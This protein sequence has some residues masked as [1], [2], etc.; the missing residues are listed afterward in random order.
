MTDKE[1]QGI[2]RVPPNRPMAE[3]DSLFEF[4]PFQQELMDELY[5]RET[6]MGIMYHGALR[7][8]NDGENPDRFSLA[9]HSIREMLSRL[10]DHIGVESKD[11]RVRL[12]DRVSSLEQSWSHACDGSSSRDGPRNWNGVIDK[13]LHSFLT[14][15]EDFVEWRAE[16]IPRRRAVVGRTLRELDEAPVP[17]SGTLQELRISEWEMYHDFFVSVAHHGSVTEE[18]FSSHLYWFEGY[19][20]DQ[21]RPRTFEEIRE[22]E[23]V[24]KEGEARDQP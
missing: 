3:R 5:R 2:S 23:E 18:D 14:A 19:L 13:P 21:L 16:N 17:L 24:I 15:M 9:A 7:V 12:S 20:L 6:A 11:R 1:P 4:S 8:L 10:P 22:I